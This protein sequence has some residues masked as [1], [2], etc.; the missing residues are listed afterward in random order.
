[1]C[2]GNMINLPSTSGYDAKCYVCKKVISAGVGY[3]TINFM[4][5]GEKVSVTLCNTCNLHEK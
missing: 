4:I 1:M 2:H 5:R 3:K